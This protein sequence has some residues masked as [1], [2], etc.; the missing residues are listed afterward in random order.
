MLTIDKEIENN[1]NDAINIVQR[2]CD[3]VTT[4][5]EPLVYFEYL[6]YISSSSIVFYIHSLHRT[7]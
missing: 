2:M 7:S 6:R 1:I 5:E 3:V 4:D